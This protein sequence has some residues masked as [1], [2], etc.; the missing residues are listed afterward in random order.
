MHWLGTGAPGDGHRCAAGLHI[1]FVGVLEACGSLAKPA[2]GRRRRKR[3][4]PCEDCDG[5]MKR[6][7]VNEARTLF[8]LNLTRTRL[9]N[10]N[11]RRE[12]CQ[13]HVRQVRVLHPAFVGIFASAHVLCCVRLPSRTRSVGCGARRSGGQSRL[14]SLTTTGQHVGGLGPCGHPRPHRCRG[15][16]FVRADSLQPMLQ[17][18][19]R[20]F[21]LLLLQH[22][23]VGRHRPPRR[24]LERQPP[25]SSCAD[26]AR[27]P[28][29][30]VAVSIGRHQGDQD[31]HLSAS[32]ERAARY[33]EKLLIAAEP[34]PPS[35]R[36]PRP[37]SE[38]HNAQ[39]ASEKQENNN[40]NNNNSSNSSSSSS[41]Q[42]NMKEVKMEQD[43]S[44]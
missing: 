36:Q 14:Q 27:Q 41:S 8:A 21:Q 9:G 2:F 11:Q 4:T 13:E 3:S 7:A 10:K 34:S 18:H 15:G 31:W 33:L 17:R 20:L 25:G 6:R 40:N 24:R 19:Q 5:K 28:P 42:K 1:C 23:Q 22:L 12:L 35:L 39:S 44:E 30:V 16:N 26:A 38:V 37:Q 43:G 29:P 32:T